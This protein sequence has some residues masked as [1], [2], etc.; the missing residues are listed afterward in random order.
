MSL[1]SSIKKHD[2]ALFV[3]LVVVQL[4]LVFKSPR[5]RAMHWWNACWID[6]WTNECVPNAHKALPWCGG[7]EN[8][9]RISALMRTMHTHH[10]PKTTLVPATCFGTNVQVYYMPRT[11]E[12][13]INPVI[14]SR[15]TRETKGMECRGVWLPFHTAITV[16]H[17]NGYFKE[18][19]TQFFDVDAMTIECE[20]S[21][22]QP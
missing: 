4:V 14:V 12:Y 17:L 3:F 22:S 21:S 19:T 16:K 5:S 13:M 8:R 20:L 15:D 2:V 11:N 6:E 18:R 9:D 10:P 1:S 7:S